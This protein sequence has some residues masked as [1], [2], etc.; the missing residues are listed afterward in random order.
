MPRK[1]KTSPSVDTPEKNVE[2]GKYW[3]PSEAKWG[4]FVNISVDDDLKLAFHGWAE[5]NAH[6]ASSYLEDL[7]NEGIKFSLAYDREN[8]CFISTFTGRLVLV[9]N[10]RY[11]MTSRAGTMADVIALSVWKFLIYA[12]GDCGNYAPKTG[13][14]MNWG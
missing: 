7:L 8:E 6:D 10:E 3:L 5:I 9:S 13:R 4:G 14:M 12:G 2:Q 1:A 11:A